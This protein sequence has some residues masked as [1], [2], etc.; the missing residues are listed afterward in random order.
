MSKYINSTDR[1]AER[2]E[3][4]KN[5]PLKIPLTAQIWV[6]DVCNFHCEYCVQAVDDMN[7]KKQY[8]SLKLM[9]IE[10]FKKVINNIKKMGHLKKLLLFGNGEPLC[11]PE[12]VQ[13]V[14]YAKEQNVADIIE[15]FSNGALLTH[16]LS[17]QLAD[18]GLDSLKIS[19][20]GLSAEDY[21]KVSGVNIDYAH[22]VSEI[23][24]FFEHK[25][26]CKL[27]IKIMDVMLPNDG[28]K[29][30]FYAT[31]SEICDDLMIESL[32]PMDWVSRRMRDGKLTI[33]GT[34]QFHVK[35]CPRPFFCVQVNTDGTVHPC[36][37]APISMTFG[38]AAEDLEAIWNGPEYNRFL[39]S[40][41]GYGEK[42][43][44]CQTCT[45][46]SYITM[47]SD[48]LDGHEEELLMKY[49]S[50]KAQRE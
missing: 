5:L 40:L 21:R 7:I 24:Y 45:E 23:K 30:K 22:F 18:S 46:Y 2:I 10:T 28:A 33:Y 17:L 37:Y 39:C 31:Y 8:T 49:Q 16:D 38:N 35:V 14:R 13:M 44:P 19:L 25:G 11:H 32:I 34:T 3:L 48:V 4:Y 27:H 50:R 1:L 12:F 43:G 9:E 15:T 36:C 29:E 42:P 41:L 6:S 47:P 26:N 20:Q